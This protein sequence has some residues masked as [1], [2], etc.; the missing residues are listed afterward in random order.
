MKRRSELFRSTA[1]K[2]GSLMLAA[3]LVLGGSVYTYESRNPVPEL[4]TYVDMEDS[5][6]ISEDEVPLA[7][8]KVTKKTKTKTK[9]KKI[10]MKKASKKTYKTK[11]AT[12]TKTKTTKKK[13]KKTLT[14][15]QTVVSTKTT[16]QYKKG[17]KINNQVTVEKTVITTTVAPTGSEQVKTVVNAAEKPLAQ[18]QKVQQT[19]TAKNGPISIAQAAPL[20]D[21]RVQKA[22]Q[23]LGFQIEINSGVS[24]SGVCDART[25][26]ITLKKADETVYHELGHFVAFAAGNVDLGSEFQGIY[27]REKSKYNEFNK[28]YVLSSS[29]EYFA[30][31]FRNY[32]L[33]PVKLKNSRPETYA[34]MEDALARLTDAQTI[35]ILNVYG[36]IWNK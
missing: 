5:I 32:T 4:V 8:P 34:A 12:K 21:G 36:V 28:G 23:K 22:F 17:S 27:N 24:Y 6:Q 10:K 35:R 18:P 9:K 15:T 3:A 1:V 13:S 19:Q 11:G 7:A 33:D 2:A 26:K 14:T 16:N 29:S 25:R 31:S 30:E 20:V